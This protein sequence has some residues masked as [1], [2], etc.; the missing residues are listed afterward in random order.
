MAVNF[1]SRRGV[2]YNLGQMRITFW[3]V[4]GSFPVPGAMT[5][6]YGGHTSC[7]EVEGAS[8]ARPLIV[9]AGTGLR[10]LGQKLARQRGGAAGSYDIVLSHVHWD[11]I[12]G[13]PF[14]EPAYIQGTHISMYAMRAAADE[15][16]SVIG[17]IT[18]HEFFPMPLDAVPADFEFHEVVPGKAMTIAG[19]EV[20]PFTLNHPF[21]AVGYRVAAD[22]TSVA[23]VSDTA[24]FHEVLHKKHFLRGP[25]TLTPEDH[26]ALDKLRAALV[27]AI[28]D[29]HTVVYDTHFLPEEYERFPHFGHSTPDHALEVCTGIGV[30]RL[31][32]YHHAPSHDDAT[33]DEIAASYAERGRDAGIEVVVAKEGMTLEVGEEAAS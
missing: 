12:Q 30:S 10:A 15:L 33:M 5:V 4:R 29:T 22:G 32:L 13:L 25:E 26:A 19:Y 16:Q 14:F 21:G 23:Y 20:L 8:A 28:R 7:V 11:H 1:G 18:R 2:G 6:R 27:D 9:D 24:P 17:G 31:V 3:G